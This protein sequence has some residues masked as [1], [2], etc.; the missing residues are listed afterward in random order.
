MAINKKMNLRLRS[1]A[2]A[3]DR[4][5]ARAQYTCYTVLAFRNEPAITMT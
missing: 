1:L 3:Q 4:N 2:D 5:G